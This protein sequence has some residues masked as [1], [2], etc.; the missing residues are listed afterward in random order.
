MD[1]FLEA[2]PRERPAISSPRPGLKLPKLAR[3]RLDAIDWLRGLVMVI[4]VLDHTRDYLGA[5]SV[6]P[7]EVN[8]AALFLTRW[9]THFCAPVFVF[10]AGVSAFLYASRGRSKGEISRFLLTRGLWLV[11]VELVVMRFA[12]TFSVQV[13][14]MFLQVIWAIGVSMITLAGLVYL[15]RKAIAVFALVMIAGHNLL[16]GIRAESFGAASWLWMMLH[17]PGFVHP[18]EGKT[19]FM[20]YPLIPWIGVMA[21]GYVFGPIM[22]MEARQRRKW[23]FSL[24]LGATLLFVGLR[25]ANV[26]GDPAAWSPQDNWLATLLAFINCE[27]YPPSLLFLTMTLGPALMALAGVNELKGKL[28]RMVVTIGRTPFLFYVVHAF[29]IHAVAVIVAHALYGDTA[30]LFRGMPPM[31]KPEN[32]G[33]GLPVIYAAWLAILVMLYPLCHW[34]AEV[35]QRRKDWWLSYL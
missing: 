25:A 33:L 31:A 35:K 3:P 1:L 13:D 8:D 26:Y 20:L 19:L 16:D 24:G 2:P 28:A 22:L 34:F 11:F 4:M 14:F 10:L 15:P 18:S 9:I 21:A 12:W 7:R 27:K 5:S 29:L 32:Y 23:T 30:W 17:E 6:N